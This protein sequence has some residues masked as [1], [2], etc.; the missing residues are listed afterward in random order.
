MLRSYFSGDLQ[1]GGLDPARF[2]GL[3]E[4]AVAIDIY[5]GLVQFDEKNT[6]V[7]DLA[8]RWTVSADSTTYT[9]T[10][11]RGVK[12]HNGREVTAAD[13]KYSIERL[14][15]PA[16]TS[17]NTWI[18]ENVIQGAK[19]MQDGKASEISGIRAIDRYAV[20]IALVQ[21]TGHFLALLTMP[22]AFVMAKEEVERWGP[23]YVSHPV[24]TGPF[25]LKEWRRQ[26]RIILEA[27]P[28]YFAGRRT[29]TAW[30]TASSRR[31]PRRKPSSSP[32]GWTSS[33]R[34]SPRSS[35]GSPTHSGRI[36][37]RAP[38]RWRSST[39]RST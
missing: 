30:S 39:S 12:F 33:P 8:E 32:R 21:P 31:S 7:P 35:S 10:L 14:H 34:R 5:N 18:F 24:G 16:T 4:W 38:R 27:N 19:A 9:F 17:P 23:A 22:Q 13:V 37:S 20:S 2:T 15:D 25:K 29:W 3:N 36:A 11:R 1:A 28:D 26:D 6:I